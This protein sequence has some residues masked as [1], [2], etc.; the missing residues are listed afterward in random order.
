MF[1]QFSNLNK[2]LV[3]ALIAVAVFFGLPVFAEEEISPAEISAV[4]EI[5]TGD[6]PQINTGQAI[7]LSD[8]VSEVNTNQA[9]LASEA[10]PV[11]TPEEI[12]EEIITETE[13][14]NENEAAVENNVET[15]ADTGNNS[16]SGGDGGSNGE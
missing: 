5:V 2:F 11:S 3:G 13:I 1:F 7:S 4:A 12:S 8:T 6:A 16:A 15:V 14:S 10:S 9:S